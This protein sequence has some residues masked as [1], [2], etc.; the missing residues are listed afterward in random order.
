M[1]WEL[2][3]VNI[4]RACGIAPDGTRVAKIQPV[5]GIPPRGI[6]GAKDHSPRYDMGASPLS[7]ATVRIRWLMS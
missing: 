3:T 1:M 7:F 6:P 5:P 4:D 2:N